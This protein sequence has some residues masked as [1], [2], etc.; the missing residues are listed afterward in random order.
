ML[1]EKQTIDK[2]EVLSND[3]IQIRQAT[4]IE[5]DGI[6]IARTFT[7][8]TLSPGDDI[9]GQDPKV[10]AVANTVWGLGQ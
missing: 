8:W 9:T 4:I 5:K 10:V 2:I 3:I 7:R 6:E 1:L